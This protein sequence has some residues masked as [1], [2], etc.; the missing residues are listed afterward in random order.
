MITV[1]DIILLVRIG[2]RLGPSKLLPFI[3]VTALI[4]LLA[5]RT[6]GFRLR[7]SREGAN[8]HL[9]ENALIFFGGIL[10]IFPGP[11]SDFLGFLLLIPHFREK[12]KARLRETMLG[13]RISEG[14]GWKFTFWDFGRP[15]KQRTSRTDEESGAPTGKR[16]RGNYPGAE[17]AKDVEFFEVKP[18]DQEDSP[19][20]KRKNK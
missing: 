17:G 3:L 11:L 9:I 12:I 7:P 20:A 1:L 18:S 19:E 10:L 2:S 6:K 8:S 16:S 5:I 14:Q 15:L 13:R 4:G